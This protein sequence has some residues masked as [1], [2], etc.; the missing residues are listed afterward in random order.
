[1][2]K[3]RGAILIFNKVKYKVEQFY[4]IFDPSVLFTTC[5]CTGNI[6]KVCQYT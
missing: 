4:G 3:L 2:L 5:R 1:M 6:F